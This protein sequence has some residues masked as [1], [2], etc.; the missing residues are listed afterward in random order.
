MSTPKLYELGIL[1]LLSIMVITVVPLSSEIDSNDGKLY[2]FATLVKYDES[3]NEVFSQTVHNRLVDTGETFLLEA[4]FRE[5]TA[6][7]DGV[8]IGAICIA[9]DATYDDLETHTAAFFDGNN[10]QTSGVNC[11][12]SAAVDLTTQGLAVIGPLTFDAPTNIASDET[13][14]HIGIC[15]SAGADYTDCA[16]ASGILF[17]TINTANVTL[18]ASET[19][20]ITYTFNMTSPNT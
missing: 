11:K 7:A 6:P 15:Q 19:V 9:Q 4:T 12:I 5:G 14:N 13:V 2:G 18:A 10:T 3:K 17:A 1:G 16:T 20:Q 8:Q